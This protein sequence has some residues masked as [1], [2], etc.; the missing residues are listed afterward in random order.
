MSVTEILVTKTRIPNVLSAIGS[1]T[2][3]DMRDRSRR[4]RENADRADD[5]APKDDEDART[6]A[7]TR[8]RSYA[9]GPSRP[10]STTGRLL[11]HLV[12]AMAEFEKSILIERTKAGL[13]AAIRRGAK[14]GRPRVQV[15]L[16]RARELRVEGRTLREVA[17]ELGV[18]TATLYRT[19]AKSASLAED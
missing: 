3:C 7:G 2:D 4:S 9:I 17:K 11:L 12:S 19:L 8:P 15:D 18:G 1:C 5:L 13:A 14:V 6:R 16:E 10:H